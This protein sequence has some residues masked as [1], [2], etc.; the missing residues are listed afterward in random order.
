MHHRNALLIALLAVVVGIA[1]FALWHAYERVD[2]RASIQRMA[3]PLP[4]KP[5]IAVMPF[6]NMSDDP[7]QEYLADGLAEEIINALSRLSNMFVIAR[8]STFTYKG[9]HVKIQQVAEEMGVRYVL[10]GSV[11]KTGETVR[12]AVQLVD[13]LTGNH[14]VS[15][16]YERDLKDV[17]V[18]QDDVTMRVLTSLRVNL[19][20]GESARTFA[21]GTKNLEAYLKILQA[22]E[23]RMIW[24]KESQMRA[25]RLTEEAM[26]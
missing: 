5:S 1:S 2:S 7:K 3:F 11:R 17:F 16:H 4:D 26:A 21:R 15:E 10:E 14:L 8:N 18:I 23:L 13:A 12:I 6:V 25:R 20:E 22:Y 24:N 9:R 19:T